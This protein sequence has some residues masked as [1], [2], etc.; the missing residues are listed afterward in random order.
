MDIA[1][2]VPAAAVAVAAVAPVVAVAEAAGSAVD[3]LGE[4]ALET[5]G[6]AP[7]PVAPEMALEVGPGAISVEVGQP[8]EADV[9]EARARAKAALDR[10]LSEAARQMEELE[11]AA[12]VAV[13]AEGVD[14]NLAEIMG[15]GPVFRVRLRQAGISN[16]AQLATTTTEALAAITEQSVERIERDD[17]IGQ[18]ARKVAVG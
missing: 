2:D 12:P 9:D 7:P 8:A 1:V 16:F 4:F 11:S 14:D 10:S 5:D 6:M 18:A 3:E 17:W 13:T 15:I